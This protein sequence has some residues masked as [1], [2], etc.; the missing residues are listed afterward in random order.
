MKTPIIESMNRDERDKHIVAAIK[1]AFTKAR[2]A[3]EVQLLVDALNA[4][5]T[6]FI[7]AEYKGGDATSGYGESTC[8]DVRALVNIQTGDIHVSINIEAL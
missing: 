4:I 7:N 2:L 8:G 6:A 1:D 3:G 5:R